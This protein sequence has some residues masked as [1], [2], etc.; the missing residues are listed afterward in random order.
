MAQI[1]WAIKI[2][3][4]GILICLFMVISRNGVS[5][6]P[7][8]KDEQKAYDKYVKTVGTILTEI[9]KVEF[10]L[11]G[12]ADPKKLWEKLESNVNKIMEGKDLLE[13]IKRPV[14]SNML[15]EQTI[16]FYGKTIECLSKNKDSRIAG[17]LFKIAKGFREITEISLKK[18]EV[19]TKKDCSLCQGDGTILCYWCSSENAGI[20][21]NCKGKSCSACDKT[22]I[23]PVCLGIGGVSCPIDTVISSGPEKPGAG[24]ISANETVALGNLRTLTSQEAIWRTEDTD[25]NGIKDYW[26]YDL[27]CMNRMTRADGV[28]K[29]NMIDTSFGRA[30]D[31]RAV[32]DVF[33]AIPVVEDWDAGATALVKAAK[34]GYFYRA[35]L[36]NEN[37][38]PYNV[39]TVGT[40]AIAATN[41]NQFAFVAYPETYGTTGINTFI[42]NQKGTVYVCDCGS[43][44]AKVVLQWPGANPVSVVG[45]G[46]RNWKVAD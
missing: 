45:P 6:E 3:L 12:G 42:V 7:K 36:T 13:D 18:E 40:N 43:D 41:G 9:D 46:G 25:G 22:G 19:I 33:G 11:E 31:A 1:K 29:V 15:L 30:D 23:C 16:F 10:A 14:I 44:K 2:G 26:T 34:S 38:N 20:C 37:G 39:N 8:K 32:D 35:M 27:S 4:L 17:H 21:P 24:R 28:T 5:E